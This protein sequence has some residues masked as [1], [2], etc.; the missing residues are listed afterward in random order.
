MDLFV[1]VDNDYFSGDEKYFSFLTIL[2][3]YSDIAA[4]IFKFQNI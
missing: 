4:S 3:I 2:A 1:L